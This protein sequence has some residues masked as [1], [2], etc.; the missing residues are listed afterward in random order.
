MMSPG[1]AAAT[2]AG[3]SGKSVPGPLFRSTIQV[4]CAVKPAQ[5]A[6]R[7]ARTCSCMAAPGTM[8]VWRRQDELAQAEGARDV[9]FVLAVVVQVS[10]HDRKSITR[11]SCRGGR[12][13][14]HPV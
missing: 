6:T 13:S 2:A 9:H 11:A 12:A 3:R 1:A 8:S 4:R 7:V 5:Q 14:D 10:D